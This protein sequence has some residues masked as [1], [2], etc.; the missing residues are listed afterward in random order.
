MSAQKFY[1]VI[2]YHGSGCGPL[3]TPNDEDLDFNLMCGECNVND[4]EAQN[5][6]PPPKTVEEELEEHRK[7]HPRHDEYGK[8]FSQKLWPSREP[9][10]MPS[11]SPFAAANVRWDNIA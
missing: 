8:D 3:E 2:A 11:L 5:E 9:E 1:K 6:L 10:R 4:A 7:I